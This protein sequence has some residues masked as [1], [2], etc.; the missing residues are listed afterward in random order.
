MPKMSR[1][2]SY[3]NLGGD[4]SDYSAS[5]LPNNLLTEM[6]NITRKNTNLAITPKLAGFAD[7]DEE[8]NSS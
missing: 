4:D 7:I 5:R 8:G 2:Q 3:L 6:S 1:D